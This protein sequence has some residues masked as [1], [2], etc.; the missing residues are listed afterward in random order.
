MTPTIF[1]WNST[2]LLLQVDGSDAAAISSHSQRQKKR[3]GGNIEDQLS[4]SEQPTFGE[5]LVAAVTEVGLASLHQEES[6]G[7][8]S[9]NFGH[10]GL[11]IAQLLLVAGSRPS[12]ANDRGM[13]ALH[14]AAAAGE[15][16]APIL[17]G[18][19]VVF[20]LPRYITFLYS[21]QYHS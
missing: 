19:Q 2:V 6:D 20:M 3:D 8:N 4:M 13:N 7:N 11:A 9:W 16:F 15:E 17:I 12:C 5:D 10:G 21:G 14:I 1:S 18:L